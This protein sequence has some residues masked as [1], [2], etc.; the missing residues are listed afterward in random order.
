MNKQDA[1]DIL[2]RA[3][4]PRGGNFFALRQ[5]DVS[6]LLAEADA[7]KYRLPRNANGSRGRYFHDFVQRVAARKD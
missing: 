5:S 3:G 7:V 6:A 2:H 4:I 1:I